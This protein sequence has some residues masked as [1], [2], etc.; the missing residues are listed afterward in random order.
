MVVI[1]FVDFVLENVKIGDFDDF[2]GFV[3]F[4]CVVDRSSQSESINIHVSFRGWMSDLACRCGLAPC[5][6]WCF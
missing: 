2:R 3:G 5:V 6:F 1:A 4:W